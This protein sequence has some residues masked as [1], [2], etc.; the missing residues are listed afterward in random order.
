MLAVVGWYGADVSGVLL[1]ATVKFDSYGRLGANP[2]KKSTK[3]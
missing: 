2:G 1:V 3:K